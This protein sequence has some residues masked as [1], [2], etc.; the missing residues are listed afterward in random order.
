MAEEELSKSSHTLLPYLTALLCLLSLLIT[1]VALA[2][3]AFAA[4]AHA[5]CRP[6][7]PGDDYTLEKIRCWPRQLLEAQAKKQLLL[8]PKK[9]D[10]MVYREMLTVTVLPTMIAT[11]KTCVHLGLVQIPGSPT[12][13]CSAIRNDRCDV[14]IVDNKFLKALA[15]DRDVIFRHEVAHCLGWPADHR[16]ART[17]EQVERGVPKRAKPVK[18]LTAYAL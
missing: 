14:F 18:N 6:P 15:L 7:S 5:G 12:L 1:T 2:I 10:D 9:Y 3:A 16:G 13:A 17:L 8:P 11:R 4:T